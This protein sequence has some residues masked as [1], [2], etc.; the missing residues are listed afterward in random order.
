MIGKEYCG[1]MNQNYNLKGPDGNLKVLKPKGKRLDPKS[2][3][4]RSS[5]VVEKV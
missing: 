4:E 5:M 3:E 1:T 2:Q